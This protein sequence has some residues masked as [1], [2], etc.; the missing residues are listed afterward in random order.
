MSE[1]SPAPALPPPS[2]LPKQSS[3]RSRNAILAA[4]G[5]FFAALSEGCKTAEA[6]RR[7]GVNRNT[8]QRWAKEWKEGQS[9]IPSKDM[10]VGDLFKSYMQASPA[11]KANLAKRIFE[12]MGFAMRA[13]SDDSNRNAAAPLRDLVVGWA[14]ERA[15]REASRGGGRSPITDAVGGDRSHS[16]T[17]TSFPKS[18]E[19]AASDTVSAASTPPDVIDAQPRVPGIS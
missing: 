19:A 14:N 3:R 1:S 4:Q 10:M 5:V 7:A 9:N 15:A 16:E 13:S 8:G 6:S 18:G 11:H 12:A 17:A 2:G